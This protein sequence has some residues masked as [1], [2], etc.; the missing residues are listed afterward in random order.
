MAIIRAE[1]PATN[2]KNYFFLYSFLPKQLISLP[3]LISPERKLHSAQVSAQEFIAEQKK[4]APRD[5]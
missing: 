2:R 1:I 3:I 4:S 5:L